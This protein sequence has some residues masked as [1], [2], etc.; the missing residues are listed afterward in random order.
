[1]VSGVRLVCD[2]CG[3]ASSRRYASS[4]VSSNLCRRTLLYVRGSGNGIYGKYA[5]YR[6]SYMLL[7]S[8]DVYRSGTSLFNYGM[9]M[10]RVGN[11]ALFALYRR[12]IRGRKM[13][14]YTTT[15]SCFKVRLR[16]F[17]LVYMGRFKVM[18]GVSSRY[19]LSVICAA[20]NGGFRWSTR[21]EGG[22]P[23]FF[24]PYYQLPHY[25]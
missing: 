25:R 18:W 6:I 15:T 11:S 8:Q 1:M 2:G 19:K 9:A 20:T 12:S 10:Y 22:P 17:L 14:S 3:V 13:V 24:I 23:S 21:F 5:S 4:N 7:V 16:H